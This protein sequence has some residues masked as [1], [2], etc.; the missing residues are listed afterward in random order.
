LISL[1]SGSIVSSKKT[2]NIA[3]DM[4]R[5]FLTEIFQA[6]GCDNNTARLCAEGVVDA[7]LH[8]HHI[9]G[10]DHIYSTVRELRAG[11]LNGRP[12]VT[13]THQTPATA[14]VNGDGGPGHVT[15]IFA[16]ELALKKAKEA[17]IGAVGLV[18]GGD[19]FR[20]G[21]Y[22]EKIGSAGMA[23]MV[24][25][26]T[27]PVRVHPAGGIDRL[28][29]TNPIAFAFPRSGREPIVM[30]LATSTSAIGHVRIASYSGAP[31]PAGI[32]LDRNGAPTTDAL[33]ALDGSLTPLG[34]HKGFALGLAA[35]LFS[36][37]LIGAVLG[38]ELEQALT[39]GEGERRRGHL[40]VALDPTAF[41]DPAL[42]T[43]RIERYAA[44]LKSSRKALG[45]D[46]IYIPG[47]RGQRNRLRYQ[48]E[49]IPLDPAIW[50]HTVQIARDVGIEPPSID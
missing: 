14:R 6:V 13:I 36:G 50:E 18:G 31:I 49:G 1:A 41:G 25:T 10:T 44:E 38:S 9:Q 11:R 37:P 29:G 45:V 22:A 4:L 27:H 5:A 35:G 46:E 12:N 17:G 21:Y 15:G 23:A 39:A 33:E 47:E 8:G 7:D 2:I 34:G 32:A 16:V 30:D 40:F 3:P 24:F 28:L 48:T 19:I 42:S 43:E 26:N 20:L